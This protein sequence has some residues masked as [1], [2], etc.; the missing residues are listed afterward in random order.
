MA[1]NTQTKHCSSKCEKEVKVNNSGQ[2]WAGCI[3]MDVCMKFNL[4][5][6]LGV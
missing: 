4:P 5:R 6:S 1:L 2:H 3:M